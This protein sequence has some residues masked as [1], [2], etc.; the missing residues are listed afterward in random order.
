MLAQVVL[1]VVAGVADVVH[2]EAVVACAKEAQRESKPL[3]YKLKQ[4]LCKYQ[5]N[6]CQILRLSWVIYWSQTTLRCSIQ[7]KDALD[8][9][10]A[11]FRNCRK[12]S[13]IE[14]ESASESESASE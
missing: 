12:S 2:L 14:C 13:T 10:K 6:K 4:T 9:V 1:V 3:E 8:G 7:P 5:D 11:L